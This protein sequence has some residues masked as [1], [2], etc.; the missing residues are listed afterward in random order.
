LKAL[1][2]AK[3]EREKEEAMHIE[4]T[5]TKIGYRE[6]EMLKV[7]FCIWWRGAKEGKIIIYACRV[8][9]CCPFILP[10]LKL[11]TIC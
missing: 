5:H 2:K 6:I 8:S 1:L 10:I 3:E 9:P 4:E 7:I 11:S